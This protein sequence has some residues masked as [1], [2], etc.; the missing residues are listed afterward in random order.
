MLSLEDYWLHGND[1]DLVQRD[2]SE[3]K[4]EEKGRSDT[5]S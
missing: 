5:L 2:D 1:D 4:I 3:R